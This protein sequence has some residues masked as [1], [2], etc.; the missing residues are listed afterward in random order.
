MKIRLR[1][2]SLR[3]AVEEIDE[4]LTRW[5]T[6]FVTI[7]YNIG[8]PPQVQAYSGCEEDS[9]VI[10]AGEEGFSEILKAAREG[11]YSEESS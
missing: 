9:K 3:C 10:K 5:D 1:A 6:K 8:K 7:R 11:L 4:N 2:I